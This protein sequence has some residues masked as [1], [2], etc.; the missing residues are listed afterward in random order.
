MT[1]RTI[2]IGDLHGCADEAEA[3]LRKLQPTAADWIVWLGDYVDR[4][5]NSVGCVDLVRRREQVQGRCA[6]ILGNHEERMLE[7]EQRAMELGREPEMP[8]SHALT[9]AQLRDEH[10]DWFRQLPLFLRIPEH[11][12]VAVHAGVFPGLPIE[13]QTQRTLLHVQM[14]KPYDAEGRELY[15]D[16]KRHDASCWVSKVPAGEEHLWRFWTHFYEGPETIV[17]GHSVFDRPLITQNTFGIDGGVPFG[18]QLHA[19]VLPERRIVTVNSPKDYSRATR[20]SRKDP[21]RNKRFWVHG[22]VHTFS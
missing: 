18:L 15:K 8:M 10:Y 4:G 19:L 1:D 2:L 16:G 7:H 14:L 6:G 13:Q 11:N 21:I 9:R 17:F 22:D 5:P 3:L 20:G 12:A